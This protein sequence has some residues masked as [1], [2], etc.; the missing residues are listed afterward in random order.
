MTTSLQPIRLL[1]FRLAYDLEYESLRA[2]KGRVEKTDVGGASMSPGGW[3]ERLRRLSGRVLGGRGADSGEGESSRGAWPGL[4]SRLEGGPGPETGPGGG[5]GGG[6]IIRD[7]EVVAPEY[8]DAEGRQRPLVGG[9]GP[10]EAVYKKGVTEY[11]FDAVGD[12]GHDGEDASDDAGSGPSVDRPRRPPDAAVAVAGT[13]E[14]DATVRDALTA[15]VD[16]AASRSS[17]AEQGVMQSETGVNGRTVAADKHEVTSTRSRA[18]LIG[19]EATPLGQ[20]AT[21][22]GQQATPRSGEGPPSDA[23]VVPAGDEARGQA[24]PTESEAPPS[25]RQATPPGSPASPPSRQATPINYYTS[26]LSSSASELWQGS[27]KRK[28]GRFGLSLIGAFDRMLL[29]PED[30]MAAGRGREVGGG[31]E[32]EVGRRSRRGR[33]PSTTE[34]RM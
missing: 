25:D 10:A 31:R 7:N 34:R 15:A 8:L 16:A 2:G 17:K 4:Q 24:T 27:V 13:V 11:A 6:V 3:G 14:S 23:Q 33:S 28:L 19:S 30:K 26:R 29:P 12:G 1:P 22:L 9:H 32:A 5:G 18:A 21:P 20:Q